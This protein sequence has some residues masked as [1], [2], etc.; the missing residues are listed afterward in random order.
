[1]HVVDIK[2]KY[3]T[4]LTKNIPEKPSRDML[5]EMC[6]DIKTGMSYRNGEKWNIDECISCTCINGR[7]LC[8]AASCHAACSKPIH[9]KGRCCPICESDLQHTGMRVG[10]R[11]K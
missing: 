4:I 1:M 11:K 5:L 3:P 2:S 10:M 9:V 6:H 8:I 7:D